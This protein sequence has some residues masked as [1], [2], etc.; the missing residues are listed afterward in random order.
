MIGRVIV[1]LLVLWLAGFLAG[2]SGAVIHL[3]LLLAGMLLLGRL[4][5]PR[6]FR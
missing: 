4:L 3:L 6:P 5:E 2:F 1:M